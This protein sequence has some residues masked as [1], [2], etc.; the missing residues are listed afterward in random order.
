MCA[1]YPYKQ[2]ESTILENLAN[3][4]FDKMAENSYILIIKF[5]DS[6]WHMMQSLRLLDRECDLA[7]IFQSRSSERFLAALVELFL[8]AYF[9][10]CALSSGV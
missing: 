5:G 10:I 6:K 7:N 4:K 9:S 8:K 3:I 1:G 2:A